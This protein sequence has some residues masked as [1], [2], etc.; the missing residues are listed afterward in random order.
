MLPS[1]IPGIGKNNS[2]ARRLIPWLLFALAFV[3][4]CFPLVNTDI[5]WHLATGR[6]IISNN[7]IPD[8]DL[9]SVSSSGRAW[10]DVHWFFQILVFLLWKLGG[11]PALVLFKA[12]LFASSVL[13]LL[14]ASLTIVSLDTP[15]ASHGVDSRGYSDIVM[16]M[17]AVVLAMFVFAEY[18]YVFMRPVL[19]SLFFMSLYLYFIAKYL[20]DQKWPYLA[21]LLVIQIVWANTQALFPLGIVIVGGFFAGQVF[22]VLASKS[23]K[24]RFAGPVGQKSL[25]ALGSCLV[26]LV[27][28]S[29]CTPY[30]ADGINVALK[31]F[32]RIGSQSSSL[33]GQNVSENISPWELGRSNFQLVLTFSM[34]LIWTALSFLI[35][36]R[37][38]H[39]GMFFLVL[40]MSIPALMANRNL[41]L[42][43]WVA[44]PAIISNMASAL[45]HKRDSG[46]MGFLYS[47]LTS[48]VLTCGALVLMSVP[49]VF[50]VVRQGSILKPSPF[51]IPQQAAE[52]A[53]GL[54]QKGQIFNSVRYG[55]FLIWKLYPGMRPFIDGRLVLRTPE[56]FENY[57]RVVDNPELFDAFSMEHHLSM[58]M[59]PVNQPNRYRKLVGALY[60]DPLWTLV[61]TDGTQTLFV[62]T[63]QDIAPVDLSDK[64][65]VEKISGLLSF[66]FKDDEDALEQAFVNLGLLLNQLDEHAMAAGVV[67]HVQG[68]EAK[69]LLARSL[70]LAGD[71]E[72]ALEICRDT[73]REEADN[74]DALMLTA[75]VSLQSGDLRRAVEY[76]GRVLDEEP[77]NGLARSILKQVKEG[78]S[79]SHDKGG[80]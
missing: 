14:K 67:E 49:L 15:I 56:Q 72:H 42:F 26:L 9:F 60:A 40:A 34:V 44:G 48:P 24:R 16:P 12:V 23:G 11:I 70:Y 63:G 37:R 71:F 76:A 53:A 47:M 2:I 46:K 31:L 1:M 58:V 28:A 30:G 52:M 38:A 3:A 50:I 6:E 36:L 62:R 73:L 75:Q 79:L 27:F 51:R 25:V 61:F 65:V 77:F 20:K 7:A 80:S 29:L 66:R 4:V 39:L 57:L 5:W 54:R 18:G 43:Y 19:F 21:S 35:N 41:L 55:G 78:A 69:A 22:E 45:V 33:F 64:K 13:V 68:P 59:L 8:R 74:V 17:G 32:Y 10:V